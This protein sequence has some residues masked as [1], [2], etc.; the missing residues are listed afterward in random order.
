[1]S[2]TGVKSASDCPFLGSGRQHFDKKTPP[3]F[4]ETAVS[5]PD[6][7]SWVPRGSGN[8]HDMQRSR[9]GSPDPACCRQTAPGGSGMKSTGVISAPD[10]FAREYGRQ[11][12][13]EKPH[14]NFW[15]RPFQARIGNNLVAWARK[16]PRYATV[17]QEVQG[18]AGPGCS[19]KEKKGSGAVTPP[20]S[21]HRR[22]PQAR[23][24]RP[25]R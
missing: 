11:Y 12:F 16:Y 3:R 9:A 10:S 24:R 23:R 14:H 15:K 18:R 13:D 20:L 17:Q 7:L 8:I 21:G 2:S 25:A 5:A 19:G 22:Q 4:Q 6:W 1:M